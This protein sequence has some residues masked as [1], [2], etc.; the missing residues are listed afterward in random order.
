RAGRLVSREHLTAGAPG[1]RADLGGGRGELGGLLNRPGFLEGRMIGQMD[2]MYPA[3]VGDEE[4]QTAPGVGDTLIHDRII[5]D[6]EEAVSPSY[7][8]FPLPIHVRDRQRAV[9]AQRGEAS[10]AEWKNETTAGDLH[11][12]QQLALLQIDHTDGRSRLEAV[13]ISVTCIGAKRK[14]MRL[15]IRDEAP[16]Q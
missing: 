12:S 1:D 6:V 8:V 4:C 16:G 9:G 5:Q 15:R 3:V 13:V 14:C 7:D 2:G 10:P 11:R